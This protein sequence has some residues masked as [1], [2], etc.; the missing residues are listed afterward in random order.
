MFVA[1]PLP[2]GLLPFVE[3]A[4][5]ALPPIAGLRLLRADQLHVTLAFIGEV[6]EEKVRAAEAV[7]AGLPEDGGGEGILTGFL[8]LPSS[9]KARVVALT[10]EDGKGSFARLFEMVMSGLE[11]AGVM[12]REKRPFRPHLTVARLREPGPV[13]P[14]S[15]CAQSRYPIES[16]CLYES[17][18]KRGGAS[19]SV[20]CRRI[21]E[22]SE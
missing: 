3:R 16:V 13:V 12:K 17:E 19:Y 10:I 18:L 9:R 11:A 8:L 14:K 2:A 21:M 20:L 4:Q 6:G 1:I 7:V 15:E 22:G 5:E